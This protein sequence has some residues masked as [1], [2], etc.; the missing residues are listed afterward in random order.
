M[1]LVFYLSPEEPA[2]CAFADEPGAQES[3][4]LQVRM[5]VQSGRGECARVTNGRSGWRGTTWPLEL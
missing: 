1:A 4:R 5:V 2:Q 3:Q